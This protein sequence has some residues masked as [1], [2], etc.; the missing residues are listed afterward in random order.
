LLDFVF[1]K[2][3]AAFYNSDYVAYRNRSKIRDFETFD[4]AFT[5][6]SCLYD[7]FLLP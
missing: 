4:A 7:V 5:A 1:I 3:K 2:I 6:F